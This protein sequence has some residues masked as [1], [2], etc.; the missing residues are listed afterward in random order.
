V[1]TTLCAAGFC[2]QYPLHLGISGGLDLDLAVDTLTE[3]EVMVV[4]GASLNEWTTHFGKILENG[5][6]I[7]QVDDREDA[8]GWFAR[9]TLGVEADSKV[10]AVALL[11]KLKE[12]GKP[13]RQPDAELVHKKKQQSRRPS[14]TT[15][16]N[17]SIRVAPP[18][19]LRSRTA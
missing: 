15:M 14:L 19:R 3:S 16:A 1:T 7:I 9:I 4:V 6:K 12:S 18:E 17:G 10:A 13:G 2:S 5:K 8:F 11:D